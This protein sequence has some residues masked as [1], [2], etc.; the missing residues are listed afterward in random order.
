MSSA[1][2]TRKVAEITFSIL[3][4]TSPFVFFPY[5]SYL[6]RVAQP[7]SKSTGFRNDFAEE[8]HFAN[9]EMSVLFDNHKIPRQKRR[10]AIIL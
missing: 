4:S 6:S 3:M 5:L 9:L 10:R 8:W 2:E 1:S 7:V